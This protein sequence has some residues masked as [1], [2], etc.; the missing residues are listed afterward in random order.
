MVPKNLLR[1]DYEKDLNSESLHGKIMN[2]EP[3]A[4][5]SMKCLQYVTK[6]L[7]DLKTLF[8]AVYVALRISNS[9]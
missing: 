5:L 7:N 4:F 1:K 6:K 9:V 3:V 8:K 2:R